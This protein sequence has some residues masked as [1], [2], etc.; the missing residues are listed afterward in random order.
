MNKHLLH[1]DRQR[2]RL[3][4]A[5]NQD[6]DL[7]AW[8]HS[9]FFEEI[10]R[11]RGP[12]W[13]REAVLPIYQ[14]K[15]HNALQAQAMTQLEE[16]ALSHVLCSPDTSYGD[17]AGQMYVVQA[18][19][20]MEK[21]SAAL[22]ALF[23]ELTTK[24]VQVIKCPRSGRPARKSFRLSFVEGA[25]YLT[26]AGKFGNQG[27]AMAEVSELRTGITTDVLQR[28]ANKSDAENYLSLICPGRTIDLNLGAPAL[29]AQWQK[30]LSILSRKEA[31][32]EG[33]CVFAL[34]CS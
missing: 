3:H 19:L 8:Y 16:T 28:T 4:A 1:A 7:Q 15:G 11:L 9:L 23:Q 10:Y 33:M 12:F 18:L 14:T 29:C 26:W 13:Y 2:W 27:V 30:L 5:A 21:D 20:E 25:I 22:F 34:F 24:G 6:T 31:E 17:V 32:G